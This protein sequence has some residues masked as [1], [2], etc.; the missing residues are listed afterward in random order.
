VRHVLV[1]ASSNI[2]LDLDDSDQVV[3]LGRSRG[4]EELA[5][6]TYPIDLNENSWAWHSSESLDIAQT[7]SDATVAQA[8]PRSKSSPTGR[9][10][11]S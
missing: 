7:N 6:Y 4:L 1:P 11:K 8:T 10:S 9:R 2:D 5:G 3:F